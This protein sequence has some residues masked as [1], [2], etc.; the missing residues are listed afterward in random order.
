NFGN[1]IP[2]QFNHFHPMKGAM[3]TLTMQDIIGHEPLHWRADRDGI[4]QFNPTFVNLQARDQELTVVEMNEFKDFLAT[5]RFP[6][7][8]FR[9]ADNSL[10]TALLLPGQVALG[11]GRLPPGSPLPPGDAAR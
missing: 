4:E 6:P 3:T 2:A 7:N 1:L 11:R 5:I 10:P 9:N 8:P